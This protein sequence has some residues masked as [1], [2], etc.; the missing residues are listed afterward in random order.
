MAKKPQPEPWYQNLLDQ[1]TPKKKIGRNC[2]FAFIGGGALCALAQAGLFCLTNFLAMAEEDAAPIVT[3][4]V[5]FLTALITGFGVYDKIA[6][7][8]GAGIAVPISG[9]ANSV[10]ASMME[11]KSEGLVLGSGCNSFK[12]AGAVV[13]FGIVSAFAVVLIGWILGLI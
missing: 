12:L 8:L 7:K 6:Q 10:V 5:I 3:V 2:F 13:I 1:Y 9:F 4:S 11:H